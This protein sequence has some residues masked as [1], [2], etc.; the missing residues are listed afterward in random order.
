MLRRLTFLFATAL[1]VGSCGSEDTQA[2]E[3]DADI[4]VAVIRTLAPEDH[5]AQT[6]ELDQVVYVGPLDE[7]DI[8]LEVQVAVVDELEEFATIRFVDTSD[9][10]IEEDEAGE[11][12]LEGGVLLLLSAVPPGPAPSVDTK[13]YVDR[14]DAVRYE[15]SLE[16][17]AEEWQVVNVARP[18]RNGRRS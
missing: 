4:Y 15:V 3:R 18:G 14:E 1:A 17:P 13:R 11:P 6:E 2:T 5:G 12:V 7:V 10:A 8:S 16:R 9:E